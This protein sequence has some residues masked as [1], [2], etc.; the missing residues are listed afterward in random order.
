MLSVVVPVFNEERS[1]EL[2][3]DEVRATLE[4]LEREWEV[5]FVDD[6]SADG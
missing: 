3:F 1:V 4:P 6:G 2:L 5:V